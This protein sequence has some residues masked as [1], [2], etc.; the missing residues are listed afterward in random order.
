MNVPTKGW[1]IGVDFDNTIACYDELMHT[2]ALERGLIRAD[3]AKNKKLI[4]DAIR[5]L[6]DGEMHWR[7]LQVTAYGPQMQQARLIE[8]VREFFA[9]CRR[10]GIPIY[11]VSHKTEYANFGEANVD[12]RAAAMAWLDRHGFFSPGELGLSR[13]DVFFEST[14]AKKIERIKALRAT[15]FVD[16]LE[17]TFRESA[18]PQ[19]VRKILFTA[20]DQ[21][22]DAAGAVSFSTWEQI[23]AHL[24]GGAE[25]SA[26]T[27]LLRKPVQSMTRI[28]KGG[29]SKVYRV[30]CDDGTHHAAKFYFQSTMD[31]LDRLEIEFSSLQFLWN[32]GERCVPQP[33]AVD[34][35]SQIAL[36]QYVDGTEIDSRAVSNFDIEQLVNFSMRLK[37]LAMLKAAD[38]LPRAAEACFSFHALHENILGRLGRLKTVQ[39]E[40]ASYTALQRF[41]SQEFS[42]ALGIVVERARRKIGATAWTTEL[43]RHAWT[44]SPSDFGF[45]NALRRADG[46]IVFLDFEYFGKDD[47][48]KMIADFVLHPAMELNESNKRFYVE[49]MLQCFSA[50]RDLPDRLTLSYPLFGL[51]W[52]MILLNEFVPKYLDRREFAITADTNR[53]HVRER[54]L[55]KSQRML[56]KIMNEL[57]GFPTG[58]NAHG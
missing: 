50:D 27:A 38:Q 22:S 30:T 21:T 28:G 45:H 40:D 46:S 26:L 5:A 16:D 43:P 19:D 4:R 13:N 39:G 10:R 52:C 25:L 42:P 15:H 12:L 18:F 11:I 54:Q 48:A 33:L 14:R 36:Y 35:G 9:E 31:G 44:L 1:A 20:R 53:E 23:Y 3:I 7:S 8:G 17:E 2:I 49:R 34:R 37:Q 29:N 55:L 58:K 51:K 57:E 56:D 41:L 47:P 24:L 32:N 6:P